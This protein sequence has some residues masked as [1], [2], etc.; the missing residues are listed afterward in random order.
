MHRLALAIV[1]ALALTGCG[2]NPA[3][4]PGSPAPAGE[5][6]STSGDITVR[7]S[8]LQTSTLAPAVASQYGIA[9]DDR[10]VMLLV[11]V[12]QG[13]DGQE[14]SLP[15]A[16]TASA[17]RL[18]GQVQRIELRELRSGELLDYVG[19][20][21]TSLPETLRFDVTVVRGDG[22]SSTLRFSREFYPR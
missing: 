4:A 9:R 19:T 6:I 21:E 18:G 5:A 20:V 10:T 7:A 22:G 1:L 8:A 15:A 12:R 11:G 16:I 13:A 14:V 17:T 2:G 3:P